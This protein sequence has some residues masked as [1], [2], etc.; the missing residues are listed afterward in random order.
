[1][2]NNLILLKFTIG[3]TILVFIY[4]VCYIFGYYYRNDILFYTPNGYKGINGNKI[5]LEPNEIGDSIGGVLNPII[6]ILGIILTFL[7]FYIQYQAN[8]FQRKVFKKG[9]KKD[10]KSVLNRHKS[11]LKLYSKLLEN[12][13]NDLLSEKESYEIY[14]DKELENPLQINFYNNISTI[15][16]DNYSKIGFKEIYESLE[17]V[18]NTKKNQDTNWEDYYISACNIINFYINLN[19][20]LNQYIITNT[21][22][23]VKLFEETIN[24]SE[25]IIS[26]LLLL[27][28]EGI[29]IHIENYNK[30]FLENQNI[31]LIDVQ[32]KFFSPLIKFL[33][34]L[35]YNEIITD[36]LKNNI[37]QLLNKSSSINK[38]IGNF[39]HKVEIGFKQNHIILEKNYS[40]SDN[41]HHIIN[42]KK[43]I[44]KFL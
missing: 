33:S 15:N 9:L 32:T 22:D 18:I 36:K 25:L 27:E 17:Y 40:N 41:F 21:K 14:I 31:N 12:I 19:R 6:G 23:K 38:K 1:M 42:F 30:C 4:C 20:D 7:A 37:G 44:D 26:E 2:K 3:I 35:Y 39:N 16:Y 10:S 11:N 29:E 34:K 43:Y 28:I 8:E 13:H 5:K 24:D